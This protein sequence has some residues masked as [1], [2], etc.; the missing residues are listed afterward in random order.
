MTFS[1]S[2]MGTLLPGYAAYTATNGAVEAMTRILAK[3]V[4]AKAK[5]AC[6]AKEQD[7]LLRRLSGMCC[8]LDSDMTNSSFS[9]SDN[10]APPHADAYTK[11]GHSRAD[12]RK[13]KGPARKW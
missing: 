11:E 12:D 10:D 7:C 1:S 8:S 9:S 2:I 5:A 3:E 4:A 6:H 13:G